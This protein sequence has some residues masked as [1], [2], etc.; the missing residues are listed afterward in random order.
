[1]YDQNHLVA[2]LRASSL[3]RESEI[4]VRGDK[5]RTFGQFF[6]NAERYAALL[7]LRVFSLAIV[8]LFR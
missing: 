8:W 4:F 5:G 2:R 3:G 7:S 1:M 6:D